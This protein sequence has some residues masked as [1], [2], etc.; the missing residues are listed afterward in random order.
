VVQAAIGTRVGLNLVALFGI[1][2]QPIIPDAAAKILDAIG[3]PEANRTWKFNRDDWKADVTA[4]LDALPRGMPI[5]A[6]DVLFT[7]IEDNQVAEWATRF[8]GEG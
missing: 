4:I 6:P 8:G 2:A 3:V 7:K 5:Q 1:L